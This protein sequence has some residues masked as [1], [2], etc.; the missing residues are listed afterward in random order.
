M[1]T[2]QQLAL[3]PLTVISS[4]AFTAHG[5]PHEGSVTDSPALFGRD[6]TA[7]YVVYPKDTQNEDQA[8]A[9]YT[10]LKGMIP[11]PTKIF[12]STTDNGSQHWFWGVPLTSANAEKVKGDSN[13]RMGSHSLSNSARTDESRSLQSLKNAHRIVPIQ[14]EAMTRPAP[15]QGAQTIVPITQKSLAP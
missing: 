11:D 2:M 15:N 8:T 12:N 7:N 14:Q 3:M 5:I 4:L 1:R 13:V 9:I 10:L 6:H